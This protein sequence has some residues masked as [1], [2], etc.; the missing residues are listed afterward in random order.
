MATNIWDFLKELID[1]AP[2]KYLIW[3]VKGLTVSVV[4]VSIG[5]CGSLLIRGSVSFSSAPANDSIYNWEFVQDEDGKISVKVNKITKESISP[6]SSAG[7][8]PEIIKVVPELHDLSEFV[9]DLPA[10]ANLLDIPAN[11]ISEIEKVYGK[12]SVVAKRSETNEAVKM[13]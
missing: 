2:R 1:R 10:Q 12:R 11:V 3:L 9:A 13:K 5:V 6:N 7:Q 4:V 8:V